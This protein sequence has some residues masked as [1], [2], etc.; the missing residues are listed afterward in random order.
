MLVHLMDSQ[1]RKNKNCTSPD[2]TLE[3]AVL[4]SKRNGLESPSFEDEHDGD[5]DAL[6]AHLYGVL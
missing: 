6:D 2:D 4:H 3:E 5:G 1:R